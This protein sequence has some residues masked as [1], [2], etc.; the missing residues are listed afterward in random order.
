[1]RLIALSILALLAGCTSTQQGMI[2]TV[3][4]AVWGPEDVTVSD[5]K[6]QS[7]PFSTQYLRL[8]GGQRIFVGLGYIEQ[9]NSK[10]LTQDNAMLVTHQGR[11]LKTVKLHGSNLSAV[12]ST[13]PDP[14]VDAKNLKPGQTWS[15]TIR[16][17]EGDRL[18]SAALTSRFVRADKDQVLHIAGKAIP[19]EVWYEEVQSVAPDAQWRNTFW[20]DAQNGQVRQSYQMLGAGTYPVEMTM[21]KPAP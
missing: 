19:C 14:L 1:M 21:L 7:I 20:I 17:S 6:I 3:N 5:A 9:G 12:T 8:N 13:A 10:W 16:W 15:R 18:Y 4:S 11:L 2:D